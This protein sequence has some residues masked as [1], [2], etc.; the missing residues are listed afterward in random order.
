MIK[1]LINLANELDKKG[2]RKEADY[3]DSIVKKLAENKMSKINPNIPEDWEPQ[4]PGEGEVHPNTYLSDPNK[5]RALR[6]EP[7]TEEE[8]THGSES[9]VDGSRLSDEEYAELSPE[10]QH[11]LQRYFKREQGPRDGGHKND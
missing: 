5:W 1:E 10:R 11:G 8:K 2:L 9:S 4:F 6:G 3:L 7:G